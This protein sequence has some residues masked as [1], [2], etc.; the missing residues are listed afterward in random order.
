M[1]KPALE[2]DLRAIPF[3]RRATSFSLLLS[4][5]TLTN[6]GGGDDGS[7]DDDSSTPTQ[8]TYNW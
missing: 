4:A 7:D 3:W 1:P 5:T 2:N 6:D 8:A